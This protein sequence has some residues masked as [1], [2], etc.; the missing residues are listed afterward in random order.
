MRCVVNIFGIANDTG[1]HF[2]KL[3]IIRNMIVGP[4][5]RLLINVSIFLISSIRMG[6]MQLASLPGMIELSNSARK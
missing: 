6:L 5:R 3:P 2:G 4:L 1:L